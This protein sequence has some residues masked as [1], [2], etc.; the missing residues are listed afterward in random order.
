MSSRLS[1]DNDN[2]NNEL[3]SPAVRP[4][5]RSTPNSHAFCARRVTIRSTK[6]LR[7]TSRMLAVKESHKTKKH[8]TMAMIVTTM[9]KICS[10]L[11]AVAANVD[12]EITQKNDRSIA[13]GC[14]TCAGDE[15]LCVEHL[16]QVVADKVAQRVDHC[17][18]S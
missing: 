3:T 17:A 13:I 8:M 15:A 7:R 11:M 16:S 14:P 12:S 10:K 4:S 5:E 1:V 6:H 2:N 18:S 9:K